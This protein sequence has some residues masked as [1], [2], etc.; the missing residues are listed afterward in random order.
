[1]DHFLKKKNCHRNRY[2]HDSC[3][4]SIYLYGC[5]VS[6]QV[7]MF[8]NGA[9]AAPPYFSADLSVP[10][11]ASNTTKTG[12]EQCSGWRETWPRF[13]LTSSPR[14][15]GG[16]DR[17]EL[18]GTSPD[19]LTNLGSIKWTSASFS[20]ME[21]QGHRQ[22][23]VLSGYHLSLNCTTAVRGNLAGQSNRGRVT[24]GWFDSI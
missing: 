3:L 10:G 24:A 2:F 1:M 5:F 11:T 7:W 18:I 20:W 19:T 6:L 23:K 14:A 21:E 12:S 15:P 13:T 22:R 17:G 8:W 16:K 9:V 4:L